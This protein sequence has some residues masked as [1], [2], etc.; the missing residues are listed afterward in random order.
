MSRDSLL[1]KF[2]SAYN[3]FEK[4]A[5]GPFGGLLGPLFRPGGPKPPGIKGLQAGG[6]MGAA[7]GMLNNPKFKMLPGNS[8]PG[9]AKGLGAGMG[10]LGSVPDNLS[11]MVNS[12]LGSS[13]PNFANSPGPA[14]AFTS[15]PGQVPPNEAMGGFGRIPGLNNPFVDRVN[16][17][18]MPPVSRVKPTQMPPAFFGSLTRPEGGN[19]PFGKTLER[20]MG[21]PGSLAAAIGNLLPG[22]SA[23][24]PAP[25]K[26]PDIG[27]VGGFGR[28]PGINDPWRDKVESELRYKQM[29][30]NQVPPTPF[31][32]TAPVAPPLDPRLVPTN[33]KWMPRFDPAAANL[34]PTHYNPPSGAATVRD[35]PVPGTSKPGGGM[36]VSKPRGVMGVSKPAPAPNNQMTT[37]QIQEMLKHLR[38]SSPFFGGLSN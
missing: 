11:G 17:E 2:L 25:V 30:R 34:D 13:K 36:G 24:G 23:S 35:W 10:G 22:R 29:L 20:R 4:S 15:K 14:M 7:P 33:P 27:N 26:Q 9:V 12:Y 32:P 38:Q 19:H 6:Q 5:A 3:K 8:V 28:I 31:K 18:L 1:D 37:E 21:G 16:R